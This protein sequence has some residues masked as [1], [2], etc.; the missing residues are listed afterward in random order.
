MIPA[1]RFVLPQSAIPTHW[2][3][4][5][6]DLPEPLPPPL[7]PGTRA[8]LQAADMAAIFPDNL[9][10]QEMSTDRWVEIPAAVQRR[11]LQ[12]PAAQAAAVRPLLGLP[13]LVRLVETEQLQVLQ[14]Q[15]LPM[16]EAAAALRTVSAALVAQVVVA[17]AQRPPALQGQME[18]TTKAV[19]EVDAGIFQPLL[20]A[21]AALVS[22][23][24]AI[25]TAT[26]SQ[27]QAAA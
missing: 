21:T 26:Q 12:H 11:H 9:V 22:S 17:Q 23:S 4:I 3:N 5:A 14:A 16:R 25:Q 8:T 6:A 24:F 13:G 7:H 15:A 1:T 27:T 2:Y 18:K 10:A 19:A 20:A